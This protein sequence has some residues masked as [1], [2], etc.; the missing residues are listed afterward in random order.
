MRAVPLRS[1]RTADYAAEPSERRDLRVRAL[2]QPFRFRPTPVIP[3]SAVN[4]EDGRK[5]ESS[6]DEPFSGAS[7][8]PRLAH[9]PTGSDTAGTLSAEGLRLV[10]RQ[11]SVEFFDAEPFR[12]TFGEPLQAAFRPHPPA[13]GLQSL[14]V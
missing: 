3:A 4:G 2:Q 12:R 13:L 14:E 9:V 1:V 10:L 5:A 6:D 7:P 11:Q 8:I